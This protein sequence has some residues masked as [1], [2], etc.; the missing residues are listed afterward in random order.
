MTEHSLHTEKNQLN[1]HQPRQILLATWLQAALQ[2]Q[3]CSPLKRN[4]QEAKE[5]IF[6]CLKSDPLKTS[7]Q[8]VFVNL[9]KWHFLMGKETKIIA[10]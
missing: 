6:H 3:L 7:H 1:V 2:W 10:G 8:T 4:Q 9:G 5:L